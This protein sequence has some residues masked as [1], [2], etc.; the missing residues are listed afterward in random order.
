MRVHGFHH[1]ATTPEAMRVHRAFEES[2]PR[3]VAT[4]ADVADH[5]D[6]MREVAGIDHLGI[7]G[8]GH[9]GGT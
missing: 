6:H 8:A 5:L 9:C 4:V 1:L 2:N 7:G 3:P